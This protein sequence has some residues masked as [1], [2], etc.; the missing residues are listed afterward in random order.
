MVVDVRQFESELPWEQLVSGTTT[1]LVSAVWP[2]GHPPVSSATRYIRVAEPPAATFTSR[3]LRVEP[4]SVAPPD[5]P[6]K[7]ACARTGPRSSMTS[8]CPP[9]RPA[10]VSEIV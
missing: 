7:E 3:Q 9:A 10:L 2:L 8:T 5:A 6:A 1:V 4:F